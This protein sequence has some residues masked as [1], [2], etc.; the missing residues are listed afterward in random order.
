MYRVYA[1][2]PWHELVGDADTIEKAVAL[3]LKTFDG[4]EYPRLVRVEVRRIR[5]DG[6]TPDMR[7]RARYFELDYVFYIA[8]ELRFDNV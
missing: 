2:N 4:P 5:A 7:F 3:A 6:E 8:V 1:C